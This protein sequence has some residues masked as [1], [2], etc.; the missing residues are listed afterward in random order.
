MSYLAKISDL[1]NSILKNGIDHEYVKKDLEAFLGDT[2]IE[3]E[4]K[5]RNRAL[6]VDVVEFFDYVIKQKR[7]ILIYSPHKELKE[8]R[9]NFERKKNLI[10]EATIFYCEKRMINFISKGNFFSISRLLSNLVKEYDRK[11]SIIEIKF[12]LSSLK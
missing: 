10:K 11:K 9:I 2:K 8:F 12:F 5:R 4:A 6:S 1:P 7:F 3:L